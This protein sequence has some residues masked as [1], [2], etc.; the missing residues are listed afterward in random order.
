MGGMVRMA[1]C[2]RA[3]MS[4]WPDVRDACAALPPWIGLRLQTSNPQHGVR[5]SWIKIVW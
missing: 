5:V 3:H 1:H 2:S 4:H